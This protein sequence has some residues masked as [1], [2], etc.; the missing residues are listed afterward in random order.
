MPFIPIPHYKPITIIQD[1]GSQL[2]GLG[3]SKSLV[4]IPPL[5]APATWSHIKTTSDHHV[6][7]EESTSSSSDSSRSEDSGDETNSC[8]HVCAHC[9]T[10]LAPISHVPLSSKATRVPSPPPLVFDLLPSSATPETVHVTSHTPDD[11]AAQD[12]SDHIATETAT[13]IGNVN[14]PK[15]KVKSRQGQKSKEKY[16]QRRRQKKRTERRERAALARET[17]AATVAKG[18]TNSTFISNKSAQLETAR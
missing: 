1:D 3:P 13:P 18:S 14:A 12:V 9:K 7:S 16:N 11:K 4:S 8:Q 2:P 10:L 6:I 17:H 5:E 15:R